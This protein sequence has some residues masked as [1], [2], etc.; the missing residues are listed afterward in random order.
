MVFYD[1][2]AKRYHYQVMAW[3]STKVEHLHQAHLL[4]I[5]QTVVMAVRI[6][7]STTFTR[8]PQQM[9]VKI[10]INGREALDM[11]Q[12]GTNLNAK[13]TI[14]AL[15]GIQQYVNTI[16]TMADGNITVQ[17]HL[18][19]RRGAYEEELVERYS[20]KASETGDC[21]FLV[22]H[23]FKSTGKAFGPML[24]TIER[25]EDFAAEGEDSMAGDATEAQMGTMDTDRPGNPSVHP[26]V[27]R[28]AVTNLAAVVTSCQAR[29]AELATDLSAARAK[30]R[31]LERALGIDP[32]DGVL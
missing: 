20:K 24:P 6:L 13:L 29:A 21:F 27:L 12:H 31:E 16:G 25:E 15:K 26:G 32:R 4:G 30:I 9:K 8:P 5:M 7:K 18:I 17:F 23:D 14:D 1:N 28:D 2:G 22:G 11:I 19:Q 3:K 10:F